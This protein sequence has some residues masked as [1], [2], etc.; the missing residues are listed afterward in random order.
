MSIFTL[1]ISCLT[2]FNL[3]CLIHGPNILDSYSILFLAAS[4]LTFHHPDISTTEHFSFDPFSSFFL[5]LFLRSPLVAYWIPIDLGGLSSRVISFCLFTLFMVFSRQEYWSGCS[6]GK[7]T[8]VVFHSLLQ[9]TAFC[10]TSPPW[11][12]HLGCLPRHGLV[13]VS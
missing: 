4:N 7:N 13:S 9:W 11:P 12:I 8:E 1:A 6:Q 3:P 2:P 10:Q 5:E